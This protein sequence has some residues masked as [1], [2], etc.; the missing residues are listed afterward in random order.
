MTCMVHMINEP[1]LFREDCATDDMRMQGMECATHMNP[2]IHH[3]P[4]TGRVRL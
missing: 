3:A 2:L 1:Q 4:V